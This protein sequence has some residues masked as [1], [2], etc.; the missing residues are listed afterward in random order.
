MT[1]RE[2][3]DLMRFFD[4]SEISK[5]KIKDGEFSIELQKGFESCSSVAAP[6]VQTIAA[7][8]APVAQTVETS[9]A[10]AV[11]GDAIKSPMVGTFY[12]APAPGADAFVKV[13]TVVK[14]GQTVGIIEAMKIMNEIEAEFDCRIIEVLLDDGQPVEYDMPLFAVEKV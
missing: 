9:S 5:V 13:G 3:K 7:P 10:E 4:N 2:I 1:N 14:K 6:V 8:A 12:K 11:S